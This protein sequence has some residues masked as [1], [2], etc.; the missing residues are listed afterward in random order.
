[1][2]KLRKSSI[3]VLVSV[4]F[5]FLLSNLTYSQSPS[6]KTIKFDLTFTS[7]H[8]SVE[9]FGGYFNNNE[10]PRGF[11]EGSLKL[12]FNGSLSHF[13]MTPSRIQVIKYQQ[14]DSSPVQ[15]TVLCDIPDGWKKINVYTRKGQVNKITG[16]IYDS[17]G[18]LLGQFED[19]GSSIWNVWKEHIIEFSTTNARINNLIKS[20]DLN[21]QQ[22]FPNP[23][24][25]ATTVKYSVIS[26]GSVILKIYNELGQQVRTLINKSQSIGDYVIHWDGLDDHG[27]NVPSGAYFY[28]LTNG[29]NEDS[30]KMLLIR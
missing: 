9:V 18:T 7:D 1:M 23:F 26:D 12:T 25:S 5:V 11:R 17:S 21:L 16:K 30:Q 28:K 10:W 29:E 24:N 22:N 13:S 4:L 8:G 14:Y 20:K 3:V 19:S 27:N 6:Y 2:N 15:I